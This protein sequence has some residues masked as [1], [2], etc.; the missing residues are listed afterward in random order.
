MTGGG[1]Y[2]ATFFL[3][4]LIFEE[5]FDRLRFGIGSAMMLMMILIT[6]GLLLLLYGIFQGW[7]YEEE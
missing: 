4:L 2:Y 6:F 7:G 5:A 3:P 1:P